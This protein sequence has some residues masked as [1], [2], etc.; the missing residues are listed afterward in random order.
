MIKRGLKKKRLFV[1]FTAFWPKTVGMKGPVHTWAKWGSYSW[2]KSQQMCVFHQRVRGRFT[3]PPV[4][5]DNHLRS[6]TNCTS[7]IIDRTKHNNSLAFFFSLLNPTTCLH[8][9][10]WGAAASALM[11]LNV[12]YITRVFQRSLCQWAEL[13]FI[14]AQCTFLSTP[15]H[16][17]PANRESFPRKHPFAS[18]PFQTFIDSRFF[19][20]TFEK[21]NA[22]PG[23]CYCCWGEYNSCSVKRGATG[24]NHSREPMENIDN[25]WKIVYQQESQQIRRWILR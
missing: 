18:S 13:V 8:K 6:Q 20:N 14:A 4:K 24:D 5:C 19:C 17:E 16:R 3:D 22:A 9:S 1:S 7:L 21:W 12:S 10:L 2:N 25:D 15:R 23:R 11:L